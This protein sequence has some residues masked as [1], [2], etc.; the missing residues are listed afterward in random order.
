MWAAREN[1]TSKSTTNLFF[2]RATSVTYEANWGLFWNAFC[3]TMEV[4]GDAVFHDTLYAVKYW[5]AY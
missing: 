1:H 3:C 2:I 4:A 5:T